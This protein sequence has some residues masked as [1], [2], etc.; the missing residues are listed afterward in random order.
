M[1]STSVT[2]A[3]V[4]LLSVGLS[5]PSTNYPFKGAIG[6]AEKATIR[7]A[8]TIPSGSLSA[9]VGVVLGGEFGDV[10]LGDPQ[11][12]L[13]GAPGAVPGFRREQRQ[14]DPGLAE[15]GQCGVPQLV[16][17]GPAGVG[18]EQLGGPAVG[19][20]GQ[21]VTGRARPACGARLVRNSGPRR[22]RPIS[23]G[24]SRALP[25]WKCSTSTAPPLPVMRARLLARSR[26]ST[27]SPSSS[28]ARPA[29]S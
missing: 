22:R 6:V 14:A 2:S 21:L 18:G 28:S 23:R 7:P 1:G 19:Q 16:Q 17:R 20:P 9:A 13:G 24:S 15:V 5:T 25:D 4:S 10:V 8:P 26:S 29:V 3:R 11:V 27:L 12:A